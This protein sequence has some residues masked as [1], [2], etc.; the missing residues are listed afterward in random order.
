MNN[1]E[2]TM[3]DS[4]PNN[5]LKAYAVSIEAAGI[6]LA[7]ARTVP[8]PFRSL[9]DQAIRAAT[10]VPANISEGQGRFG[11]DRLN[12]YRIAYGS[13]MEVDTFLRRL[14]RTG[15]IEMSQA[16]KAVDL[17]DSVRAMAWRLI[18]P[19]E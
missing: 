15:V 11:R 1:T 10:S 7:L 3:H 8:A 18:H 14:C 2:V 12:H 5:T 16:Q 17:F 6:T 4:Q 19:K 13:A 9:A